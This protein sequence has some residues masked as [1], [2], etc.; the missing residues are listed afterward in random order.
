MQMG[1]QME[2]QI[3]MQMQIDGT[4]SLTA[5]PSL[6]PSD[7]VVMPPTGPCIAR[8]QRLPSRWIFSCKEHGQSRLVHGW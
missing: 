3:L 5:L 1:M 7:S 8:G 4:R 2:M 6:S